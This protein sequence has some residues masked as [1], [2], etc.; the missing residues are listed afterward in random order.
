MKNDENP[1]ACPK[2]PESIAVILKVMRAPGKLF[3]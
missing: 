2:I 3:P 1:V